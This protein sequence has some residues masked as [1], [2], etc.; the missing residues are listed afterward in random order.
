MDEL[1]RFTVV[2]PPEPA[3]VIEV[4]PSTAL[5]RAL[6]AARRGTDARQAT[7]DAAAK[8][9]AE[10]GLASIDDLP[11]GTDLAAI[12]AQLRAVSPRTVDDASEVV[13]STVG[14][15]PAHVAPAPQL[16]SARERVADE[17]ILAKLLSSDGLVASRRLEEILRAL[18]LLGALSPT[19]DDGRVLASARARS[20][21]RSSCRRARHQR[22]RRPRPPVRRRRPATPRPRARDRHAAVAA[23]P[24]PVGVAPGPGAARDRRGEPGRPDAW[25]HAG[26]D[27]GTATHRARASGGPR[28]HPR[29]GPAPVDALGG[30]GES[31][32][33]F[34]ARRSSAPWVWISHGFRSPNWRSA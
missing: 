21:C 24:A 13:S 15:D 7:K 31:L 23:H 4:A 2:R 11:A 16:A 10:H 12:G 1:F 18:E 29:R 32:P 27:G 30:S 28:R 19:P 34:R 22:N 6:D 17:L 14:R 26:R 33:R 9:R 3:D 5:G 25:T 8:Y 20:R